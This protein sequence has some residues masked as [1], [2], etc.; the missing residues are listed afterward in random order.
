MYRRPVGC[1][2]VK[3]QWL[4]NTKP[5]DLNCKLTYLIS[6]IKKNDNQ[7][8]IRYFINRIDLL[9]SLSL[10]NDLEDQPFNFENIKVRINN[11]HPGVFVYFCDFTSI[12]LDF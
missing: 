6:L 5:V 11:P 8:K 3:H 2:T 7:L 9:M 12:F 10:R 4:R 1:H